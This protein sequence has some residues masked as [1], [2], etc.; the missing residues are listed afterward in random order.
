VNGDVLCWGSDVQGQWGSGQLGGSSPIPQAS[1]VHNVVSLTANA[2]NTC[3]LLANGTVQCWGDNTHGGVGDNTFIN[4]TTPAVVAL[5]NDVVALATSPGASHTC[6]LISDGTVRC[7]G[8]NFNGVLGTGTTITP[9]RAVA[10]VNL[11]RAVA[12]TAG[13]RHTCA[14]LPNEIARCWGFDS[15]IAGG[16]YTNGIPTTVTLDA[17]VIAEQVRAGANHNCALR[18]SDQVV[19]WGDNSS[20]QLGDSTTTSSVT[21]VSAGLPIDVAAIATSSSASHSCALLDDGTVACWGA[22]ESGQLGDGS[23]TDQSIPVGVAGIGNVTAIA[24]GATHT[25]A[26]LGDSTVRC[27][28]SDRFGQ[29]GDDNT[30]DQPFPVAVKTLNNV[31]AI[32]AG[33]NITCALLVA[34]VVQCWGDNSLGQLGDDPTA[35]VTSRGLPGAAVTGL[36]GAVAIAA[37]PSHACAVALQTPNGPAASSVFCWGDGFSVPL[38]NRVRATVNAAGPLFTVP[39]LSNITG[40]T[41][42]NGFVCALISVGALRCL[43][44][45][46]SGQLG[47]GT[48]ASTLFAP[49]QPPLGNLISVTAGAN[50][51]CTLRSDGQPLCFGDGV[52][53]ATQV[54]SFNFNL[55][56]A[57]WLNNNGRS[58][59]VT[60]QTLCTLGDSIHVDATIVQGPAA[61]RGSADTTCTGGQ[62]SV[63]VR[64]SA[65]TPSSFQFGSATAEAHGLTRNF[66][67]VTGVLGWTSA[68]DFVPTHFD[69]R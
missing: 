42:G 24:T 53:I 37:G 13:Q 33:D 41:A 19:C 21:P 49:T 43:G 38:D 36:T 45:N 3:A 8:N 54:P 29:L 10:V 66:G 59:I 31:I 26:L 56:P 5:V 18:V 51:T 17:G 44:N 65:N 9:P 25:C 2:A 57:V 1:R 23:T 62:M 34:G 60:V 61:G 69:L 27:W 11:P 28:G 67:G 12:I 30:I 68:I 48:T 14:L 39:Q 46:S 15:T 47:D 50:H 52:L 55:D 58:A 16:L 32:A 4:R 40:I 20:G 22:N 35:T 64:V 63:P 6:A 7:W